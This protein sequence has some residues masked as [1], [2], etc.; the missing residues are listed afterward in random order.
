MSGSSKKGLSLSELRSLGVVD[1]N[2]NARSIK[3][4]ILSANHCAEQAQLAED[5]GRQEDAF[6]GYL[7]ALGWV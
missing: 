7:R 6:V 5:E 3:T 4:W 2:P 1:E